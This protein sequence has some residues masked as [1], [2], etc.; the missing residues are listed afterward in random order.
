MD[1]IISFS[2]K[3]ENFQQIYMENRIIYV[4]VLYY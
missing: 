1:W 2:L 3:W 4:P